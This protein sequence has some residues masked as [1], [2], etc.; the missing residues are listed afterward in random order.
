[1]LEKVDGQCH[2]GKMRSSGV[3]RRW[4]ETDP[5]DFTVGPDI[6]EEQCAGVAGVHGVNGVDMV[7]GK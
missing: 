7:S 6:Y 3:F 1:M 2:A 5:W 4:V